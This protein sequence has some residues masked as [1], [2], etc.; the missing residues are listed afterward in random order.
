[1]NQPENF[2]K[3][4]T[5]NYANK[6]QDHIKFKANSYLKN[7]DEIDNRNIK[8][9]ETKPYKGDQLYAVGYPA[10]FE[11]YFLLNEDGSSKQGDNR[12]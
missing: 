11:D 8:I 4:I 6:L 5:N 12:W 2:A 7:Y 3:L 10:S 1:M 9:E